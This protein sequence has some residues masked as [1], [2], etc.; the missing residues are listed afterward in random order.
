VSPF[1]PH[2]FNIES[3]MSNLPDGQYPANNKWIFRDDYEALLNRFSQTP[4][5]PELLLVSGLIRKDGR[6]FVQPL[7]RVSAGLPDGT[8][9]G[10]YSLQLLDVAGAILTDQAFAVSFVRTDPGTD[11][12]VA[13]FAFAIRMYPE[14]KH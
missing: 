12:P 11:G 6:V 2:Q 9:P 3:L 10:E 4:A 1:Q 8:V 13:P 5:D 7:Y 14:P